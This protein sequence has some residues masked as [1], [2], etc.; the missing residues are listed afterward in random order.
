M[1]NLI[2]EVYLWL[3]LCFMKGRKETLQDYF[4]EHSKKKKV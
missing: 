3:T 1:I 2:K 4:H